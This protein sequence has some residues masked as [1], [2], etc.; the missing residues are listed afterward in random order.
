MSNTDRQLLSIGVFLIIVV[1]GI[2]LAFTNLIGWG[3]VVP[4]VLVL[5]GLWVIALSGIRSMAPQKYERAPF[6]TAAAGVG[7]IV[8]G[9]AWY[10]VGVNW[11]LALVLVL[12]AIAIVAIAAALRRK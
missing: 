5:C 10:L 4:V 6:S 3:L 7:L 1:V 11:I 2:L 8:I 9:G 12:L